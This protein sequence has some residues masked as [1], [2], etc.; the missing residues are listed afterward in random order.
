MPPAVQFLN[1]QIWVHVDKSFLTD[2]L[3]I[4]QL[5]GGFVVK[6]NWKKWRDFKIKTFD[7]IVWKVNQLQ[8]FIEENGLF[9]RM[10]LITLLS[11]EVFKCALPTFSCDFENQSKLLE[12]KCES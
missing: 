3:I 1:V 9:V 6:L 12:P 2:I 4:A 8:W 11:N 7:D 10:N 5:S